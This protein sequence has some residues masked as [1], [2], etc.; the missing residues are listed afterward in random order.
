MSGVV[1]IQ[2]PPHRMVGCMVSDAA[3]TPTNTPKKT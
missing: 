2:F 1:T 3:Y